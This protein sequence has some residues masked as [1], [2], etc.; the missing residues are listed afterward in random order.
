M[1]GDVATGQATTVVL[2]GHEHVDHRKRGGYHGHE[3]TGN[4]SMTV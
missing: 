2:D 1:C 4:D 3:I